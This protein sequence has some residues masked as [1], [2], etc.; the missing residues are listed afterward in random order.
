MPQDVVQAALMRNLALV[1][2]CTSSYIGMRSA[3]PLFAARP[4]VSLLVADPLRRILRLTDNHWIAC[5]TCTTHPGS[6]GLRQLY[7]SP[8]S[9][10]LSGTYNVSEIWKTGHRS[11]IKTTF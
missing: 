11:P 9:E 8:G 1:Y 5:S 10:G 2:P 7:L 4:M 6:E 3:Q